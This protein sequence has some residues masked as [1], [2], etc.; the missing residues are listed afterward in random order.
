MKK[1][2]FLNQLPGLANGSMVERISETFSASN[3]SISADNG[4]CRVEGTQVVAA[5]WKATAPEIIRDWS[6]ILPE[7]LFRIGWSRLGTD[8]LSNNKSINSR[9]Q[10]SLH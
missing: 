6:A 8:L 4:S 9:L 3:A 7:E 1:Q 10:Q 5:C 2:E